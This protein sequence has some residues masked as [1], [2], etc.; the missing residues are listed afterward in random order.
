MCAHPT[1]HWDP[2]F[3]LDPARPAPEVW[4]IGR[5]MGSWEADRKERGEWSN[6]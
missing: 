3:K 2:D 6:T 5:D 1:D 4:G